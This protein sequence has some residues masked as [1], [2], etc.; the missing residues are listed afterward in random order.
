MHLQ[1]MNW[2]RHNGST[3]WFQTS[4]Y[5]RAKVEFNSINWVR[6]GSSTT[7]ETGLKHTKVIAFCLFVCLFVFLKCSSLRFFRVYLCCFYLICR[8]IFYFP[9]VRP[10][11]GHLYQTALSL[12]L[13]PLSWCPLGGHGP[14]NRFPLFDF[15]FRSITSLCTLGA[16]G[17]FF[18]LILELYQTVHTVISS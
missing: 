9:M 15:V 13:I 2:V 6:N 3:T 1:F 4:R 5:C 7:F 8:Q 11:T 10:F 12:A 17:F 18:S 14:C 16:R